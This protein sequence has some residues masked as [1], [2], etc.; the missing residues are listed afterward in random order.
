MIFGKDKWAEERK[1]VNDEFLRVETLSLLRFKENATNTLKSIAEEKSSK[2]KHKFV[3][4]PNEDFDG[5]EA[6]SFAYYVH[7]GKIIHDV[8]VFFEAKTKET[9]YKKIDNFV[10]MRQEEPEHYTPTNKENK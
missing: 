10:F 2:I 1:R 7:N 8:D 6:K 4:E 3:I 9:L 5:F